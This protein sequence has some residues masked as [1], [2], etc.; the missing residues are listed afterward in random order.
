MGEGGFKE[1]VGE[2][3]DENESVFT[4]ATTGLDFKLIQWE[5]KVI[6]PVAA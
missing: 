4:E 6:Q 1:M 3:F 2:S 5:G